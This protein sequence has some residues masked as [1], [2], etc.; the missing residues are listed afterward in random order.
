[1]KNTEMLSLDTVMNSEAIMKIR[2]INYSRFPV[3]LSAK[4]PH[5]VAILMAK[6][7]IGLKASDKTIREL[8]ES[9]DIRLRA[10]LYLHKHAA[11][12]QCVRSF[13][14]GESHLGIVCENYAGTKLLKE[15]SD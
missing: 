9:Q 15:L 11:L 5:I 14:S 12:S 7:L 4:D 2:Q 8:F 6:T 10:P 1:L 13:A 3:T